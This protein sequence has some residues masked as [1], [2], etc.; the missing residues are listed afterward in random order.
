MKSLCFC[1]TVIGHVS[2]ESDG[3]SS[4]NSLVLTP[5]SQS[6]GSGGAAAA[7]VENGEIGRASC[8]ER[9]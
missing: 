1:F 6:Q 9:V 2:D 8:R 4:H 7:A 5:P 3:V